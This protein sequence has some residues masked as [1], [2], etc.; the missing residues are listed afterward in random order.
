MD[1]LSVL[2]ITYLV[3]SNH[4]HESE[5]VMEHHSCLTAARVL[6][7][8]IDAPTGPRPKVE[9]LSGRK[10]PMLSA[11]CLPACMADGAELALLSEAP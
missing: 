5:M 9:L 1:L 11:T 7:A 3:S 4:P 10:V 8:A 2:I 6:Q